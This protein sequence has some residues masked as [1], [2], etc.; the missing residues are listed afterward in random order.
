MTSL[1]PGELGKL[2]F[3]FTLAAHIS[4]IREHISEW[5]GLFVIG[6]HTLI[7]MGAVVVASG[8]TGMALSL[9]HI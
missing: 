1:Q 8:D 7:M 5:R 2:I 9:I 3:I 4:E 6:L